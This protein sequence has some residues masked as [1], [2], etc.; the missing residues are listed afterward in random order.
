MRILVLHGEERC[1][2]RRGIRVNVLAPGVL[3]TPMIEHWLK[4]PEMVQ[5]LMDNSPMG[6][7]SQ[8]DE[9][10][11]KVLFLCSP[12]ASFITGQLFLVDTRT[13]QV[14]KPILRISEIPQ[15]GTGS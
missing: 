5:A 3:A 7:A 13:G 14:I 8:P 10:A 9:M 6:R 11:G 12:L 2:A 15:G 1:Y 4:D